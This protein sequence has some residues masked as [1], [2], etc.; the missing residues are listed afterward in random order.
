MIAGAGLVAT[1]GC[2]GPTIKNVKDFTG[3]GIEDVLLNYNGN[4]G[5]EY[6]FVGQ[7]DGTYVRAK[8]NLY[9]NTP[10][11][12]EI[13]LESFITENGEIYVWDGEF[14]KKLNYKV[15]ERDKK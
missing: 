8:K 14:Y 15:K 1:T 13:A 10:D 5:Q 4:T 7:K 3:D 2:D 9:L 11:G 6:L 12:E